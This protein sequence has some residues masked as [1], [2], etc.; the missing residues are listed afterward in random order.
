MEGAADTRRHRSERHGDLGPGEH[1]LQVRRHMRP[2]DR[3]VFPERHLE[4]GLRDGR[5]GQRDAEAHVP[6]H[7]QPGDLGRAH[8]SRVFRRHGNRRG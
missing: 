6:D 2:V 4:P 1:R 7:V 5:C 3:S 8:V